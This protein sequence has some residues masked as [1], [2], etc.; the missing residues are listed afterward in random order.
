MPDRLAEQLQNWA[1]TIFQTCRCAGY[2]RVDFF[3]D[4][5]TGQLYFNEINTLPGFTAISLFPKAF[6]V[7]GYT[8]PALVDKLCCLALESHEQHQRQEVTCVP[9]N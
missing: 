1:K 4:E 6:E 8:L 3:M 9:Q 2:A 5:A 7:A